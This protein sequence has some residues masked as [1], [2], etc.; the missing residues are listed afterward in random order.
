[1]DLYGSYLGE[2][3]FHRVCGGNQQEEDM[4]S[5]A[6]TAPIAGVEDAHAVRDSKNPDAET[7]RFAGDE[8]RAFGSSTT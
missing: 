3:S 6:L 1:M 7:L 8:R 5:C 2:V 4:E